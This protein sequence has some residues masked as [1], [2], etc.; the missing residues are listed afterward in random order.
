MTLE[1]IFICARIGHKLS[2]PVR[3]IIAQD[4]IRPKTV[5]LRSSENL[6]FQLDS[7]LFHKV[8]ARPRKFAFAIY[9]QIKAR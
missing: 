1:L 6:G 9:V 4:F 8:L 7:Q 5:N 2:F 3:L